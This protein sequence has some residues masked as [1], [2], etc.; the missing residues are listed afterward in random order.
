MG[1]GLFSE[2][3]RTAELGAVSGQQG[4]PR[5]QGPRHS[6]HVPPDRQSASEPGVGASPHTQGGFT[7]AQDREPCTLA[8]SFLKRR[9][10]LLEPISVPALRAVSAF[11][12]LRP[13]AGVQ[14]RLRLKRQNRSGHGPPHAQ[15]QLP[16]RVRLMGTAPRDVVC[17]QACGKDTSLPPGAHPGRLIQGHWHSIR[18]LTACDSNREAAVAE[19][20]P[21]LRRVCKLRSSPSFGGLTGSTGQQ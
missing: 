13:G 21:P 12:A 18:S 7:T 3:K 4:H 5:N 20:S 17:T 1:R 11:T 9:H 2:S 6:Q 16:G 10:S 15:N 14:A 19:D 8:P